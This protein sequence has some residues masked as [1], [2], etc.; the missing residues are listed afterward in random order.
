MASP[1]L[2]LHS[3]KH[4][5]EVQFCAFDILAEGGDDLRTLPLSMRKANL[6]RPGRG[7][8]K[9]SSSIRSSVAS[10]GL[11]CFGLPVRW[12]LRDRCLDVE[13]GPIRLDG[14]GTG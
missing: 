3:R 4:D 9:V 5:H 13:T 2:T 11:I 8:L 1:I 6:E 10:L 12:G 14:A 7:V